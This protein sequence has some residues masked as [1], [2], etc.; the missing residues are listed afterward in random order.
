MHDNFGGANQY[1]EMEGDIPFSNI[2]H[3]LFQVAFTPTPPIQKLIDSKSKTVGLVPGQ[4]STAHYRADY[5]KEV[6]RHPI[7]QRAFKKWS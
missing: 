3:D 7:L 6:Q 2:Y 1:N 5:G 4:Y